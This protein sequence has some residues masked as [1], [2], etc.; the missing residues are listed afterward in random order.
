M[1]NRG[2]YIHIYRC[3]HSIVI[4]SLIL[5]LHRLILLI[6]KSL[7]VKILQLKLN[8]LR[9]SMSYSTF[10]VIKIGFLLANLRFI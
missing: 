5:N 4:L 3:I 10:F 8:V 6:K 2:N 9:Y 1:Y 7:K